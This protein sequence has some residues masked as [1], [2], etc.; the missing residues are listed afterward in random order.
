ML[1][2]ELPHLALDGLPRLQLLCDQILHFTILIA[3]ALNGFRFVQFSYLLE[4]SRDSK[5]ESFEAG[6]QP[7]GSQSRLLLPQLGMI[8][9]QI[10]TRLPLLRDQLTAFSIKCRLSIVA[11]LDGVISKLL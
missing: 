4:F 5:P 1:M 8:A 10:F 3:L 2:T 6:W 9:P 7:F 11:L